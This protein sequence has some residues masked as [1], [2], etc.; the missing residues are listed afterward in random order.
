MLESDTQTKKITKMKYLLILILVAT[1]FTS[2]SSNK[3]KAFQHF[4][5]ASQ[6]FETSDYGNASKE[7]ELAINLDSKNNDF[8]IL[9]SKIK[10]KAKKIDEAISL[11]KN[12]LP[13]KFKVDTVNYL[14]GQ[15]YF[16]QSS[17]F[18]TEKIDENKQ[19]E[20]LENAIL[21][22]D[23][24][25]SA[26]IQY[27]D[28]YIIKQRSLHNL[29]KYDD[30]LITL[31]TAIDLFPDSAQLI[32]Y[33]GVEKKYLGDKLGAKNDLNK[34]I[35]ENKLDSMDLSSAYRFRGYIFS[36]EGNI[37]DAINDMTSAINFDPTNEYLFVSRGNFYKKKG[38]KEKACED[39][40]KAADLG[41][42]A[43]YETIKDYCSQ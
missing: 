38:M 4:T 31:N 39:Y 10:C 5:T 29:E 22:S 33:R 42:V 36:D 17:Y 19:K 25:I 6:F 11:L 24:A 12:I 41:F 20:L 40:R 7:I 26:N 21:F 43:I 14:I 32:C 30:A 34:S 1:I 27:F 23:N 2:C 3:E 8:K 13:D 16:I 37:D 35:Q 15:Y 28:A 9:K 18:A